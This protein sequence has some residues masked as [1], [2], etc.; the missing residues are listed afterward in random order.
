MPELPTFTTARLTLRPRILDDLQACLTM[1]S[2]PEV[3]KFIPGPWSDPVQHEAFVR[4][5][6][7]A[8]FGPGLGYWSVFPHEAP[9]RFLGWVLLTPTES[10]GGQVEIGWRFRRDAWGKGFATEAA[11]VVLEYGLNTLGLHRVIAC[12]KPE[13]LASMRVA[14][15]IGMRDEA[16]QRHTDGDWQ[17]YAVRRET[18]PASTIQTEALN[19]SGFSGGRLI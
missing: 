1:N 11:K 6:I 2:D 19:R 13:N 17:V 14:T 8:D 7:E 16:L 5:L 12:I 9:D 3:T 4:R 10:A 15:K 18:S